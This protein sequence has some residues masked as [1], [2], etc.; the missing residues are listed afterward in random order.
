MPDLEDV[1]TELNKFE[2]SL[3]YMKEFAQKLKRLFG[4]IDGVADLLGDGE[5]TLYQLI[6]KINDIIIYNRG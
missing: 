6:Q 1:L 5:I 2:E 3:N 4:H